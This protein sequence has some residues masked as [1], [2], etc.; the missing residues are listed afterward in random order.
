MVILQP[1]FNQAGRQTQGFV[2]SVFMLMEL[3]IGS[4]GR[5]Q[6]E[7][8][9]RLSRDLNED[10][11]SLLPFEPWVTVTHHTAQALLPAQQFLVLNVPV[12]SKSRSFLMSATGSTLLA[13]AT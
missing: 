9:G 5:P 7:L 6:S 10:C 2:E 11:S 12:A 1:L 3:D 8:S 13:K 4:G